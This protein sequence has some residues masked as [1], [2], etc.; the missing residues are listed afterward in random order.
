MSRSGM[1]HF[2]ST[3][4]NGTVVSTR[5]GFTVTKQKHKGL[6]FVNAS[7]QDAETRARPQPT[8]AVNSLPPA[9]TITFVTNQGEGKKGTT[10][11]QL[12][13]TATTNKGARNS[14]KSDISRRRPKALT[15]RRS[16]S[17][18]TSASTHSSVASDIALS[19]TSNGLETH[20]ERSILPKPLPA[21][22]SYR[23]PKSSLELARKL[24]F[25]AY[26]LGPSKSY[27]L[28]E[29]RLAG[30]G[31]LKIPEELWLEKDPT[32]I[33]CAT[34]LG[35]LYD[36]LVS[37]R[38]EADNLSSLTSKIF[39]IINRR[40]NLAEQNKSTNDVTI[41]GVSV[42]AII[43]GYQGK[44]DHWQVHMKGL[45]RLL[46]LV[47]GQDK[48]DMRTINTIR[49]ADFTGAIS[50]ATKPC[51]PF[52]RL[53]HELLVPPLVYD[54]TMIRAIQKHLQACA[55]DPATVK[56][57][58]DLALFNRY[59][60]YLT[61]PGSSSKHDTQTVIEEYYFLKH[62]LLSL[63]RPLTDSDEAIPVNT[64][65]NLSLRAREFPTFMLQDPNMD[66]Y[67]SSI[68][69]AVRILALL[70]IRDPTLDLP[71]ESAVLDILH[72]N[73]QTMLEY[74]RPQQQQLM[75]TMVD[76]RLLLQ[77]ESTVPPHTPT[78]LW[79][80]ITGHYFSSLKAAT[81]TTNQTTKIYQ[82]LLIDILG[83]DKTAHPERVSDGELE[84]CRYLSLRH[85]RG[86]GYSERSD[87]GYIVKSDQ[88]GGTGPGRLYERDP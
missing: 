42:L 87:I 35:V 59:M 39:S 44:Y 14:P 82:K 65:N 68:D 13:T 1:D 40:L 47:G 12:R 54:V 18:S 9:A 88:G 76:P 48:L 20:H 23:L 53:H 51:I 21:W 27:V 11:G 34:T 49:K 7:V 58:S 8:K 19:D 85:L 73:I 61:M 38:H 80:C 33:Q 15:R 17:S 26:A 31:S 70:L 28:D 29:F 6:S 5:R 79:I 55:L 43:A 63:P 62:Q 24:T 72:Q 2:N 50:S 41:H 25:M 32:S 67:S 77:K 10:A 60:D 46:E 22:A 81:T 78:L 30:E 16:C 64:P 74:R 3:V 83:P 36:T 56:T 37:G 75:D 52:V 57:I 4:F 71:C 66:P 45:V 84:L 86:Q 69:I